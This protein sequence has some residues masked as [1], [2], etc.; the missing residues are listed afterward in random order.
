MCG[1]GM[2]SGA[3]VPGGQRVPTERAHTEYYEWD[4]SFAERAVSG[5][6]PEVSDATLSGPS[7]CQAQRNGPQDIKP[8]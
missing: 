2:H 5:K 1:E 8:T 4:H 3:C 7:D 6:G